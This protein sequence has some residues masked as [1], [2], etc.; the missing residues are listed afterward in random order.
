MNV[1]FDINRCGSPRY[2]LFLDLP[3]QYNKCGAYHL[4]SHSGSVVFFTTFVSCIIAPTRTLAYASGLSW[5]IKE[6][7]PLFRGSPEALRIRTPKTAT[8]S[9]HL[10]SIG[11]IAELVIGII[12]LLGYTTFFEISSPKLLWIWNWKSLLR[13]QWNC[14]NTQN[15]MCFQDVNLMKSYP[16]SQKWPITDISN[17]F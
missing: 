9:K 10:I 11:S 7:K 6:R 16:S 13:V 17:T 4:S 3:N 8:G 2:Y 15:F 5:P 12:I 1:G 14:E